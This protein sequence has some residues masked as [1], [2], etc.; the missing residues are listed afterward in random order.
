MA[1]NVDIPSVVV[2]IASVCER[3][4]IVTNTTVKKTSLYSYV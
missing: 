4:V 2:S 1:I 3:Y